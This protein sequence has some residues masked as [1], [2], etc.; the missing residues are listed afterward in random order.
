LAADFF[1]ADAHVHLVRVG[2]VVTPT[3]FIDVGDDDSEPFDGPPLPPP[4]FVSSVT[5][6]WARTSWPRRDAG[7]ECSLSITFGFTAMTSGACS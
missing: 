1:A 6:P 7:F 3:G 4:S 5:S 2:D